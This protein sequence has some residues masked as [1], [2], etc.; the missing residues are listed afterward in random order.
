MINAYQ[1]AHADRHDAF[2]DWDDFKN[3]IKLAFQ[4]PNHW[5][6]IRRQLKALRQTGSIQEYVHQ[7]RN[8]I[9]QTTGMDPKDQALQFAEGLKS[10]TRTYV[11]FQAPTDLS[12]AINIAIA[13]DT[14]YFGT[15]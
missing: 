4:P 9:G 3:G 10:T 6:I 2:G 1:V 11:N 7:F 13:Y 14:A 12:T 15:G 5:Q 8:L